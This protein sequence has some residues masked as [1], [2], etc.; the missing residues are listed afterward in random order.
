MMR[1]RCFRPV[2]TLMLVTTLHGGAPIAATP[3]PIAFV[4]PSNKRRF[5]AAT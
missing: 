2:L 5:Y 4:P 3:A 1:S